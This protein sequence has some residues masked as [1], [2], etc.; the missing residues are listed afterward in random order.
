MF[1]DAT[2]PSR[3]H[4]FTQLRNSAIAFGKGIRGNLDFRKSSVLATFAPNDIDLPA[5]IFGALWVGGTVSPANPG[6]TRAELA[7]Q[8]VDSQ[9]SILVTHISLL[10]TAKQ[11]CAD[12]GIK[13]SHI[14]LIGEKPTSFNLIK[15][16]TT[17][18]DSENFP[19]N[20]RIAK[21]K[22]K[23]DIAFLVYSSG[24]TGLPKG[25]ELTHHNMTANL[26]QIEQTENGASWDGSKSRPGVPDVPMEKGDKI[27]ACLPF[28][29]VYGLMLSLLHPILTGVECVVMPRFNLEQWCQLVQEY[30]ATVSY[31][32]PPI[33]LGL[34]KHP[35]VD[36]YDLSSIRMISSGAA[37]LRKELLEA[38][39][40]RKGLRVKQGYGLSETGAALFSMKW[41]DWD[42]VFGAVGVLLPNLQV[43]FCV[44]ESD[45]QEVPE[46]QEGEIYV[47]GPNIFKGYHNNEA[48]TRDCLNDGWFR[49]GDVG[50]MDN[51]GYLRITDRVKELI[52]YKGFQ[53]APA[54]LEGYLGSHDMVDDVAVVGVY[55]KDLET[56]VPRAFIVPRGGYQ[57]AGTEDKK[58]IIEWMNAKVANHKKLRGGIKFVESIPKNPSGKI[59]RRILAAEA[60]KE[61]EQ[62]EA[63]AKARL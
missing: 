57:N 6:Y 31:L 47:K 4:T 26:Q 56:E 46:G 24:T 5:V 8:L 53:V 35:C 43:K 10:E 14:L 3:N 22:P 51:K 40:K 45:A 50:V 44:P 41:E 28:Y 39:Y 62:G 16:W 30:Q 54:E 25:V 48:G 7:R 9:A 52:K 21:I 33:L 32:V 60:K 36:K 12:A 29:H 37:P 19:W 34:A 38:V 23:E 1:R 61:A 2:D 15:H 63:G 58:R 18:T 49:T 55:L 59:L 17:I 27:L 11:A 42:K 13:D 20:K